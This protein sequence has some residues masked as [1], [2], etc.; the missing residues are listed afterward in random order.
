M[1]R[2]NPVNWK[3]LECVFLKA[4]FNFIRQTASHR[5]YNK[6]GVARP[7]IIPVKNSVEPYI[8]QNNLRTA[9]IS[10]DKYFELLK[11]C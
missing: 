8:I 3:T 10:R 11:N 4:G 6:E 5:I 1:P 9:G 7:V 2:I